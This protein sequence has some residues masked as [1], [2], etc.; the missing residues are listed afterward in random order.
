MHP[1]VRRTWAPRGRT[2]LLKHRTR[3]HRKISCIGGLSISPQRRH[4]EWYLKF[5]ADTSIRQNEIITFLGELL[6]H[7]RG[8]V[9]LIWDRLNAHRGKLVRQW[10]ARRPRVQV[11]Y[12]P[13]Y[14]PELNPNEYG[15]INLKGGATLAN[16]CPD[17]IHEL[18]ALVVRAAHQRRRRPG[19]LRSFVRATKLPLRL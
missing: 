12:L 14:A 13:P 5:H 8:P 19:L 16:A 1:L 11:E 2:P 17:D 4:L 7:L 6:S 18:S 15:W 9:I 3:H 10:L